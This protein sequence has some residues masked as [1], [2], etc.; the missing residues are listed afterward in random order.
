ML[1]RSYKY[2]VKVNGVE[3]IKVE[4][5]VEGDNPYVEGLVI[6]SEGGESFDLDAHY[7]A[8]VL[9]FSRENIKTLKEAG[10]GYIVRISTPFGYTENL[11]VTDGGIFNA[12]GDVQLATFDGGTIRPISGQSL[13]NGEDDYGWLRFVRN[14]SKNRISGQ[15]QIGRAH[16]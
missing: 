13:F 9:T 8:R 4:A 14:V 1:F 12:E 11:Y 15:S 5:E 7:E 16:V 3:D 6:D 10:K 2:K